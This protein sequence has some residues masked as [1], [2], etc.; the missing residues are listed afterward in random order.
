MKESDI[1]AEVRKPDGAKLSQQ[2]VRDCIATCR[3]HGGFLWNGE[4]SSRQA[5][6]DLTCRPERLSSA[7]C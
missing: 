7:W 1:I 4:L 5:S 3:S 2:G 6:Q